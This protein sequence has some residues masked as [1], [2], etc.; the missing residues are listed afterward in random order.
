VYGKI[1]FLDRSAAVALI[2]QPG[3]DCYEVDPAAV[4]RILHITSGHPYHTQLLCHSLFSHA[5][6]HNITQVRTKDVD[7]VLDEVVERGLAVLKHVWEE[8]TTSEKA[9]LAGM[10]A[11]MGEHNRPVDVNAINRVWAEQGV[12]I[13]KGDMANATKGL[14][15]REIISGRDTFLFTIDLQRL[16]VQKYRRLE[17][18]NEE[19]ADTVRGWLPQPPMSRLPSFTRRRAL[20]VGGAALAVLVVFA[21]LGNLVASLL[22]HP[23]ATTGQ[24]LTVS[25][26]SIDAN[27]ICTFSYGAWDCPLTLRN[28]QGAAMAWKS[29]FKSTITGIRLQPDRGIV[30]ERREQI[31]LLLVPGVPC[32]ASAE[33]LF[34]AARTSTSVRWS[35]TK[36]ALLVS[37]A[38]LNPTTNTGCSPNGGGWECSVMLSN[39]QAAV[40]HWSAT[41]TGVAGIKFKPDGTGTL[42]PAETAVV[43]IELPHAACSRGSKVSIVFSGLENRVPVAWSCAPAQAPALLTATPAALNTVQDCTSGVGSWTCTITVLNSSTTGNLDWSASSDI[44]GLIFNPV[45]GTLSPGAAVQVIISV[46]YASCPGTGSITFSAPATAVTVALECSSPPP[47]AHLSVT[48]ASLDFGTVHRGSSKAL[49]IRIS[50]RGGQPLSWIWSATSSWV[51]LDPSGGTTG[52]GQT[53]NITVIADT[54]GLQTGSYSESLLISS[55]GGNMTIL[56]RITVT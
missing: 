30:M 32:P 3:K 19:I 47:P 35:C 45:S 16:W 46:P 22:L 5:Q 27:A 7:E 50:N 14:L 34:S 23:A 18:V 38:S 53:T 13:P 6:R 56:Y 8:S 36:A 21:I 54:T 28:D 17:W 2:T 42:G 12:A 37:P 44:S 39:N 9:V 31:V 52:A 1:S 41:G 48:P 11:A 43:M 24:G 26:T 29:S 33:V 40:I 20:T 10:A 15:A 25:P 51:V 4:E 55:D 49:T